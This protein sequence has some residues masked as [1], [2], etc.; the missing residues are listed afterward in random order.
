MEYYDGTVWSSVSNSNIYTADGTL[1]GN[2]TVTQGAN[3]L[4]FT[5]TATN[6][7]SV[8]GSTFSIDGS[9]NRVGIGTT[10]PVASLHIVGD[11]ASQMRIGSTGNAG[12]IN[13]AR[14]S[15][16]GPNGIVGFNGASE[17][18]DFTVQSLSG[19]GFITFYTNTAGTV[20]EKVRITNNGSVGIG[21][22]TP[23]AQLDVVG[24]GAII[25]PSGTTAQQPS[26]PEF[27]MIRYNSTIGRGEMYV[28]DLNGDG[29]TGDA[30][31]RAL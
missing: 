5:S 2:R 11:H 23:R 10:A 14:G 9:N 4:A 30:G 19:S 24:T 20:S 8:D 22:T 15:D 25:V 28:N 17:S 6:G 21:T 18:A 26:T 3:T 12:R 7:F 16:G 31:W 13:F 27:G 1:S 29:T